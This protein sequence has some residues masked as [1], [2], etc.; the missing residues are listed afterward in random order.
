MLYRQGWQGRQK[1]FHSLVVVL[2]GACLLLG[3]CVN[4]NHEPSEAELSAFGVY[5]NSIDTIWLEH[6][7]DSILKTDTLAW[8]GDKVVRE[9]YAE[10]DFSDKPLWFSRMGVQPDADTLLNFLRRELPRQGLDS[11]AFFIPQIV[12]DLSIVHHLSFD[13]LGISINEVLPRLDYHLT[14][15]Y[16]RYTI[17]QRYGYVRPDRMFNR[18]DFMMNRNEY[19]RLFDY[20]VKAPEY[21]EALQKLFSD[22]RIN[23]LEASQPSGRLYRVLQEQLEKT[24]DKEARHTL[25]VN[26][27]RCRWQ[28]KQPDEN[29][30]KVLVN[31][32]ALQLWA[33]GGD[34]VL[35]MKIVCGATTT[36]TPLLHS[37]IRYMQVNPEWLIP[38]NI[39]DNEVAHRGGDSAYFARNR[40]FIV[41]RSSGD[42]LNPGKVSAE[43]LR[44]GRLRVGQKGGVGNS[45][46]RI[47]FRFPNRFDVYLHDTSNRGAFN[48]DRRT[49]SHG[50]VRV[51]KPFDLACYLL[52]ES[53]EWFLDRLRISMDIPPETTRGR[54]YLREHAEDPRPFRLVTTQHISPNVPVYIMYY[55]VYPNPSTG[56][57]ETWPDLYG[58]DKAISRAAKSFLL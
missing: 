26:M 42:T 28:T 44:S 39:I 51:Q 40:Y 34:S 25:A 36:K 20:E 33:V 4:G 35:N 7:L 58:Y 3:S 31:I 27:E 5:V 52:P 30:R 29:G 21:Q 10:G 14:M 46:G 18:M 50:C 16:V 19:V 37:E 9:H 38:K 48:R 17:G 12:E 15:A 1:G 55:T 45:L 43:Q 22:D 56:L 57:I 47:V 2:S 8:E 41:D 23:Y 11:T 49:L 6:C 53:D 24:S 54:E 32:P 13:S